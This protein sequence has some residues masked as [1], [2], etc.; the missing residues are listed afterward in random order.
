MVASITQIQSALNFLL[1]KN[2]PIPG[3]YANWVP[4][5]PPLKIN[6]KYFLH[7]AYFT[8]ENLFIIKNTVL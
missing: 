6:I 8:K 5:V 4:G 2:I 1:N 3:Y 7:E